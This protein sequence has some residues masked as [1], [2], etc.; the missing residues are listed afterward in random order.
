[1]HLPPNS[2]AA[3]GIVWA[4]LGLSA[5]LI[6]AGWGLARSARRSAQGAKFRKLVVAIVISA[7]PLLLALLLVVLE[8]ITG[9]WSP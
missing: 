7:I 9:G 5:V 4:S 8:A 3:G 6:G 1:L 2:K